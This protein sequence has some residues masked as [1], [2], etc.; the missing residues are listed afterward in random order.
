MIETFCSALANK[1]HVLLNASFK[2]YVYNWQRETCK[3]KHLEFWLKKFKTV[4]LSTTI[5]SLLLLLY[6]LLDVHGTSVFTD[7]E[8]N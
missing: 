8:S 1:S 2:C 6:K 7:S 5:A 3:S 4:I